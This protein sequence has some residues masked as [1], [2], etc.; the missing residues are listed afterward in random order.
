MSIANLYFSGLL[1]T[2]ICVVMVLVL[3]GCNVHLKPRS[4]IVKG[5][6][7]VALDKQQNSVIQNTLTEIL[8]PDEK[9][10]KSH[11]VQALMLSGQPGLHVCG[12]VTIKQNTGTKKNEWPYYIEFN[13]EKSND[14]K[15]GQIGF[16]AS[17]LAKVN[18]VCRHHFQG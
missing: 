12:Y 17:K 3:S 6:K 10:V 9:I 11:V 1:K 18:F 14:V 4:H 16:D 7:V 5:N 15:R 2:L 8:G 13:S